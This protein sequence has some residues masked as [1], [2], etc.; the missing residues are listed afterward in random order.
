MIDQLL[1]E[2]GL[3]QLPRRQSERDLRARPEAAPPT[4]IEAVDWNTWQSAATAA[5]GLFV[6]VPLLVAWGLAQW[7]QRAPLPGSTP[8]PALNRLLAL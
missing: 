7:P 4:T 1:R 5:G 6:L 2:E 8:I 3:A